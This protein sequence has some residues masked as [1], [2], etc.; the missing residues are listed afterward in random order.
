MDRQDYFLTSAIPYA[1]L[2]L[3]TCIFQ[4]LS[5]KRLTEGLKATKKSE[6]S[7]IYKLFTNVLCLHPP[8]VAGIN[9][10]F[11]ILQII[12]IFNDPVSL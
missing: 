10:C 1:N 4:P 7:E 2:L 12:I 5:L 9:I 3:Y 8:K 11:L 6:D